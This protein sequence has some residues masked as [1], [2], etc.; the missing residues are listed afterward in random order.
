MLV[1]GRPFATWFLA[2][3]ASGS[4]GCTVPVGEDEAVVAETSESG[5]E[6]TNAK[7]LPFEYQ[8]QETR[9][10]CGPAATR[11]ALS[12]SMAAPSQGQLARDLGTTAAGT[13]NIGIVAKVMN[14]Y[15]G[16]YQTRWLPSDPAT[17]SQKSALWA[18]IV[19]S[20]DGG[21][22]VVANIVAPPW[23]HPVGYPNDRT[24]FHYIALLGYSPATREVFVGDSAYFSNIKSYWISFDKLATLVPPKGYSAW[25]PRGT[26]CPGFGGL[27]R[28]DI[29]KK[30]ADLGGC[31]GHLGGPTTS[32]LPTADR[33]GRY[34]HFE[35]GSIYWSPSTGAFEIRGA[36]RDAWKRFG[37]ESGVLGYPVSDEHSVADGRA[38][39]SVFEHGAIYW[40]PADGAYELYGDIYDRYVTLGRE[41]G[42]LGLPISGEYEIP[43]GRRSDFEH[44]SITWNEQSRQTAVTENP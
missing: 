24:V 34:N 33:A 3:L 35:H 30:Y 28:G 25:F 31:E 29:E 19:R 40:T 1:L 16:D 7:V 10:W 15:V 13:N 26:T 5:L 41:R 36:I 39:K 11:I 20:I 2:L 42:T 22:A 43:G 4:V 38:R 44:G 32:E 12:A 21:H 23:N 9:W 8:I 14:K 17:A 6:R 18:D 37:F 27:V